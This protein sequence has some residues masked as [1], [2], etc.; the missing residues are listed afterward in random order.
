MPEYSA[1]AK[2]LAWLRGHP[3]GGNAGQIAKATGLPLNV[4]DMTLRRMLKQNKVT[5]AEGRPPTW[6]KM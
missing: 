4:V 3:S 1:E 2:I 6:R 5:K